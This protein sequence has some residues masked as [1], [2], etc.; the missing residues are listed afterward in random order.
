MTDLASYLINE[1]YARYTG[2]R[3]DIIPTVEQ[4][5]RSYIQHQDKF[6]IVKDDKIKG[7]AIFFTLSDETYNIIESFDITKVDVLKMLL[8]E[9]GPN[10]HFVL[11]AAMG[12]KTIL[13]GMDQVKHRINPKTISWWNPDFTKL[14]KF[15]V[16]T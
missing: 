13:V 15:K 12:M 5:E 3:L 11:L 6:I 8:L 16:R 1:Y 9:A 14:H 2:T 10:V 4:I 7:V